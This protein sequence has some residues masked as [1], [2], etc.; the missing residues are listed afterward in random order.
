MKRETK[1]FAV[2]LKLTVT[3]DVTTDSNEDLEHKVNELIESLKERGLVAHF[4]SAI[5]HLEATYERE[6]DE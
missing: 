1:D 3:A 5:A 4:E 6:I 2:Q